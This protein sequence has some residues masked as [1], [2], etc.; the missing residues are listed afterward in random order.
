M[1]NSVLN[2]TVHL[3]LAS[4][5]GNRLTGCDVRIRA[6]AGV[7][8]LQN[9][10]FWIRFEKALSK[11]LVLQRN[12]QLHVGHWDKPSDVMKSHEYWLIFTEHGA[13]L[14]EIAF[15]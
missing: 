9:K 7:A 2:A 3:S 6:G 8:T 5:V 1:F 11:V 10:L 4:S 13:A 15:A 14:N 12:L